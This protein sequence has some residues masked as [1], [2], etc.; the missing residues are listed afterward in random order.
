M[1]FLNIEKKFPGSVIM[2]L[3]VTVDLQGV[4]LYGPPG[5]GKTMLL[6]AFGTPSWVHHSV[7]ISTPSGWEVAWG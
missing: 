2:H 4:L 3:F 1:T 5:T 6:R 7:R